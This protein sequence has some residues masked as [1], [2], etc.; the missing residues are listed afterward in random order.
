[1]HKKWL[2]QSLGLLQLCIRHRIKMTT[3]HRADWIPWSKISHHKCDECYSNDDED[4]ADKPFDQK[5]NHTLPLILTRTCYESVYETASLA[6][7][8]LSLSS[9]ANVTKEVPM[10]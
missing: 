6:M 2:I 1:M 4:E 7:L 8:L 10:K 5:L 9:S 3:H